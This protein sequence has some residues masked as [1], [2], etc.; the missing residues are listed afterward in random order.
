MNIS[1]LSVQKINEHMAKYVSIPNSWRSKNYAFELIEIIN[2]M[3]QDNAMADIS[4]A[5]YHT[6]TVD[7][8]KY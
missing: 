8:S 3:V 5:T 4:L 2:G 1:L 6:L 7:E